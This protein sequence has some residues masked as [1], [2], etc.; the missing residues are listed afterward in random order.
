MSS[1]T[2]NLIAFGI[3]TLIFAVGLA[4]YKGYNW[5]T[6]PPVG[7]TDAAKLGD[8]MMTSPDWQIG[9][10]TGGSKMP[11]LI[12]EKQKLVVYCDGKVTA[13]K[14]RADKGVEGG[15]AMHDEKVLTMFT[16]DNKYLQAR[17]AE[18]RMKIEQ[19]V[20]INA[21]AEPEL[22]PKPKAE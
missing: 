12:N 3:Y 1:L 7:T 14:W 8:S 11:C 15:K 4:G 22:L 9:E 13:F 21:E 2:K 10:A 19:R 5:L 17:Y 16:A 18:A 6:A 20:F